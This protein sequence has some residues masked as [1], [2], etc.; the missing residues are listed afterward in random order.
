MYG[1]M[2]VRSGLDSA[3]LH[4]PAEAV[5]MTGER[6]LVYVVRADGALVPRDV[7]LGI[8]A[9]DQVQVLSGVRAGDRIVASANFLVDAESRLTTDGAGMAGMPGME[10]PAGKAH[11]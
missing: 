9:G 2:Y 10:T 1:T 6:N 8:R 7:V 11:P 3:L 5:V 4:V